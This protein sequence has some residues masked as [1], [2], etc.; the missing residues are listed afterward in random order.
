MTSPH[1]S[2]AWL[3]EGKLKCRVCGLDFSFYQ[4]QIN[5]KSTMTTPRSEKFNLLVLGCQIF[6]FCSFSILPCG[7]VHLVF[8]SLSAC[9]KQNAIEV[10]L[11]FEGD[12]HDT[13]TAMTWHLSWTWRSPYRCLWLL[14]L[15][16]I[17]SVESPLMQR[18][19][20][21]RFLSRQLE[22]NKDDNHKRVIAGPRTI[23]LSRAHTYDKARQ[24][25]LI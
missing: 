6:V 1:G 14:S 15:S 10:T 9:E 5:N 8:I 21:L 16:V 13:A 4:H 25:A 24:P 23:P 22:I 19:H 11:F 12:W 2:S 7:S 3:W 20:R 17:R 18:W